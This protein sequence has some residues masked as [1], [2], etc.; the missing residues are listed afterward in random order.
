MRRVLLI[1]LDSVGIDPMGHDRPDSVYGQSRFLFPRGATG[2]LLPVRNAPLPG[3]L[4]E[5]DVVGEDTIGGIECAIT[6]TSIFSGESAIDRHGLMVGLGLQEKLLKDMVDGNNLFRHYADP[7]LANALFPFHVSFL[8][9]SHV[10]DSLPRMDR[11]A[12]EDKWRFRGQPLRLKGRDK[13]GFA[14]LFTQAEIN[15]NIFVYA[16]KTAGVRLRTWEDVRKGEALTS[17]LTHELEADFGFCGLDP[18]PIHGPTQAADILVR[19]VESHDFTFYKYQ[20]SDLISHTGRID[21]ARQVFSIIED[22]V[23][24]ILKAVDPKEV[25]VIVTSDHGHLEQVATSHAH[26][27]M[28]VPTWF[29]G[30][31]AMAAADRLRRPEAIFHWLCQAV[32]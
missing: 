27:K 9:S 30:P 13:Y 10:E 24:A 25:R 2:R 21:L 8:G 28:R 3:A 6:Y 22:F 17:S 16:A 18:L 19:L 20:L 1:A 12:V 7:C 29:F 31:D 15:Q 11:P 23:E 32:E 26:P 5:T 4:V 14:E